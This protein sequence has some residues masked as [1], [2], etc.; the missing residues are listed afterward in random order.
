[1]SHITARKVKGKKYYYL[2]ESVKR[3]AK[4]V[5]ESVYLGAKQPDNEELSEV[6]QEFRQRLINNGV[7]GI[8]AP[9]T[10][11][12]THI[13]AIKIEDAIKNKA[14][15]LRSLSAT[16]KIDFMKRERITFI[17]D[18]NAIEGSTL[19]YWLTER[20]VADQKRIERLQKRG[21]AITNM[22][23]EEQ[24]ALNLSGCLDIYETFLAHQKDLSL[25]MVLQFHCILLS[26]IDGYEQYCG[27]WRP[28]N[29]RIRGSDHVFPHYKE[30]PELME[31]LIAWYNENK[32][33][34]HPAE[35]AAKF[36]TKFTT[37]HPFADG[38]GRMARLLMNYILQLNGLPFTNIPLR[39]RGPYMKT[40][41][42]G[43]SEN[44]K[45]FVLF[46]ANEIVKQ[47]K[48]LK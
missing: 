21:V 19:D 35:L 15:F 48:K 45:P 1:M 22:D 18:S 11:F 46:L 5:K 10:E 2:E 36:H 31:G 44:Y 6:F 7:R 9:F 42:A 39:K 12:L 20:I 27:V 24:E 47:N 33:L 34:V 14:T 8:T 13:V 41:A 30:V 38:N 43:S 29:V 32:T 40:Q 4:W 16:Q 25:K 26:K 23:R 17:T 3:G 28:V 37:I